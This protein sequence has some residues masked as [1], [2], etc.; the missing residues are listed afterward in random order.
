MPVLKLESVHGTVTVTRKATGGLEYNI[1]QSMSGDAF[2]RL[3]QKNFKAI[4]EFRNILND[5]DDQSKVK[6]KRKVTLK[7][8]SK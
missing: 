6:L 8:K 5:M 3:K 2:Q 1:P 7:R 4:Q